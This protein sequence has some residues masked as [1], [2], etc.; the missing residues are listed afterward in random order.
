MTVQKEHA[1]PDVAGLNIRPVTREDLP[2]LEWDG[3][4]WKY[5]PMYARLFNNTQ[6]GRTLMWLAEIKGELV[7]QVF[8]MLKSGEK[9]AADGENRAYVFAFR[10]KEKWRNRGIGSCLM[11]FV[12]QDLHQRGFQFITLN[13]A[14]D[15]PE[16]LR[17]Y[18][19]LGYKV[20]G[21]KAGIWSFKDPH[22]KVHRVNEPAWRMM[23][24]LR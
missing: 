22:G 12:E 24:R 17:L 15:N 4:F 16:A 3:L 20:T 13:V 18:K 1:S 23:K 7:G 5:R 21:S 19:R 9:D 2:A 8:V 6:A 14:K 10:V 11:D